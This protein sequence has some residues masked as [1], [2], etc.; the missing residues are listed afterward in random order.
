[1][2]AVPR[3]PTSGSSA[4]S[5]VMGQTETRAL[6]QNISLLDHLVGAGEQLRWDFETKCLS[7]FQVNHKLELSRLHHR[8][9]AGLCALK[10][11]CNVN[12]HLSPGLAGARSVTH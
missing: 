6:Q 12:S 10:D 2:S 9:V 4:T 8:K 1:M 5:V 7:C 11:A 3:K